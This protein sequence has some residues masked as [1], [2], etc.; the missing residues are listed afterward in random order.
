MCSEISPGDAGDTGTGNG[1][2]ARLDSFESKEH[3]KVKGQRW[4]RHYNRKTLG[5]ESLP[6]KAG[7]ESTG[8]KYRPKEIEDRRRV[9]MA[10][11]LEPAESDFFHSGSAVRRRRV[12]TALMAAGSS[13]AVVSRFNNCGSRAWVHR[14]K[15]TG[16]VR[17]SADFCRNRFCERCA[18]RVGRRARRTIEQLTEGKEIRLITLTIS[19][20]RSDKLKVLLARLL[21]AFKA[22]RR[23][24]S[25]NDNVR[26]GAY[27]LETKYNRSGG[28]WHPHLHI[29]ADCD[30]IPVKQ[31]RRDWRRLVGKGNIDVQHIRSK[32]GIA[33]YVAK[34]VTKQFEGSVFHDEDRLAEAVTAFRGTRA[35]GTFGDW[36]GVEIV[37]ETEAFDR[38]DWKPL[39]RL[40]D[41][42]ALVEGGCSSS[43]RI[44]ALLTG[45]KP[46][47]V[48]SGNSAGGG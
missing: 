16:E 37:G 2:F 9:D 46:P 12:A 47:P 42:L 38:E 15:K 11:A 4:V 30:F 21:A 18:A 43:A 6:V 23:V 31:M 17:V 7:P 8:R 22:L 1:L 14:N 26:G 44:L 5:G 48:D 24:D 33:R 40:T 19:H 25:W 35:M 27:V 41:L 20:L 10:E 28:G 29:V 13:P 45:R 34:Y 39:C 3:R 32:S 36:R